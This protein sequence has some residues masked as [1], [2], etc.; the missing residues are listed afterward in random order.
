M[1]AVRAVGRRFELT[2]ADDLDR[3]GLLRRLAALG[4]VR[5]Y[6]AAT[7]SLHDIFVRLASPEAA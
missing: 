7:A 2:P 3:A 6:E 4:E 1:T 5:H